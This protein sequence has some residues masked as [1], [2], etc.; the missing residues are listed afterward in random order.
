MTEGVRVVT[1][2]ASQLMAGIA[3]QLIRDGSA[4]VILEAI[5]S[6]SVA[7]QA[8]AREIFAGEQIAAHP[9]GPHLWLPLRGKWQIPELGA[10][11][12]ANRVTAKG[13]GFAVDGEHPNALR[14]GLGTPRTRDDLAFGLK[15]IADALLQGRFRLE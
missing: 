13:D 3:T 14:V 5:R 9:E 15:V 2:L 12:R 8:I 1:F 6:E 4:Q 10:Y 11:L 7:R